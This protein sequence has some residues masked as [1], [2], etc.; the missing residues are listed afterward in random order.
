LKY[1]F[2]KQDRENITNLKDLNFPG[3]LNHVR[4]TFD[5]NKFGNYKDFGENLAGFAP[6]PQTEQKVGS[7]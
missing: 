1:Q 2:L 3:A 7:N 6:F 4:A 5:K